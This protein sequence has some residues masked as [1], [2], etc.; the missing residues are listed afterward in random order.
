MKAINKLL[1]SALRALVVVVGTVPRRDIVG[2]KSKI[3]QAGESE[4]DFQNYTLY[5]Q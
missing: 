3:Q 1:A 4:Y 2:L 5:A